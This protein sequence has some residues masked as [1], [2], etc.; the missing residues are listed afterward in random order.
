VSR[1]SP[2]ASGSPSSRRSAAPPTRRA[3]PPGRSPAIEGF[4]RLAGAAGCAPT[5]RG[6]AGVGDLLEAVLDQSGY[7][8]SCGPS[9]DPQDE[10]R[11]ENLAELVAVA[12]EFDEARAET[13]RG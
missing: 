2:S 3:S 11:I 1:R 8:P 13:G 10:T 7:L 9:P 12:R 4:T 6:G 5:I